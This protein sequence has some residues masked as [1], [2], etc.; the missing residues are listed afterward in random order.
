MSNSI[1]DLKNFLVHAC[2]NSTGYSITSVGCGRW[3][4]FTRQ[5]CRWIHNV[6]ELEEN[7]GCAGTHHGR[8]FLRRNSIQKSLAIWRETASSVPWVLTPSN[9]P[10]ISSTTHMQTCLSDLW[11]A[12]YREEADHIQSTIMTESHLMAQRSYKKLNEEFNKEVHS[13]LAY[14]IYVT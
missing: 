13:S 8:D 11:T 7:H 10:T 1:R 9:I 2:T 14:I 5:Q 3:R 12:P 6:S 4:T